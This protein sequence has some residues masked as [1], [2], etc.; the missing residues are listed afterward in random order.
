[1]LMENRQMMR[2][3]NMH[4]HGGQ[5]GVR[6]AASK[7][8]RK[9]TPPPKSTTAGGAA[10]AAPTLEGDIQARNLNAA[11]ENTFLQDYWDD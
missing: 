9:L 6:A 11:I 1:M 4:R 10:I 3:R 5:R 8:R 2:S 7:Q